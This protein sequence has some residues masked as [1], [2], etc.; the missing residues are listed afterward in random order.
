MK[1]CL[2]KCVFLRVNACVVS[3]SA[4]FYGRM[5]YSICT[6]R[7]FYVP[8]H[9]VDFIHAYVYVIRHALAC[10]CLF[11]WILHKYMHAF[12]HILVYLAIVSAYFYQFCLHT[13]VFP[14][15]DVCFC[16]CTR[17]S[18][19]VYVYPLVGSLWPFSVCVFC[20]YMCV[21]LRVNVRFLHVCA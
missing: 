4:P 9:A 6:L 10:L 17:M 2:Y 5:R 8:M 16:V 12:A 1:K 20:L 15:V 13:C 14:Y 19:F 3:I 11:T 18:F 21:V 7:A